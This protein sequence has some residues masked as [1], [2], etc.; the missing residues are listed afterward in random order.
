[1]L[2]HE[3]ARRLSITLP[4]GLDDLDML[5]LKDRALVGNFIE[6]SQCAP[7][8]LFVT[9]SVNR[10]VHRDRERVMRRAGKGIVLGADQSAKTKTSLEFFSAQLQQEKQEAT[11]G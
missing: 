5:A 6:P 8:S 1:M 3:L 2:C 10:L 11:A 9:D 7:H 4:E